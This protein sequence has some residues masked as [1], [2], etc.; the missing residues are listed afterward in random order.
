MTTV[1]EIGKEALKNANLNRKFHMF[2][3]QNILLNTEVKELKYLRKSHEKNGHVKLESLI[4]HI[5]E[6]VEKN[7]MSKND[8]HEHLKESLK[9]EQP[10]ND[11]DTANRKDTTEPE[12]KAP[13]VDKLDYLLDHT[14]FAGPSNLNLDSTMNINKNRTHNLSASAQN[15]HNTNSSIRSNSRNHCFISIILRQC[16]LTPF[17]LDMCLKSIY[18]LEFL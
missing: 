7:I 10:T 1:Y 9:D 13:V 15:T 5:I 11:T 3:V 6:L 14:P 18:L 12:R 16:C 8:I 4:T 2:K 17:N